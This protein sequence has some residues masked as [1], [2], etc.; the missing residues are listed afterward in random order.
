MKMY[1]DTN[2]NTCIDFNSFE[3]LIDALKPNS[4]LGNYP[5]QMIFRGQA[6]DWPLIPSLY[7]NGLDNYFTYTYRN[8]RDDKNKFFFHVEYSILRNYYIKANY[9]GLDIPKVDLFDNDYMN[10]DVFSSLGY[11]D[12]IDKMYGLNIN[13]KSDSYFD[14]YKISGVPEIAALAQHYGLPTRLI[15]WTQDIYIALYFAAMG[16]IKELYT[17]EN[18]TLD[19][20]IVI[21]TLTPWLLS[22]SPYSPIILEGALPPIKVIV[23]NYK[24]NPNIC[25]Q[26]GVLTYW[27]E[28]YDTG[29]TEFKCSQDSLDKRINE[30]NLGLRYKMKIKK[31]SYISKIFLPS[32]ECVKIVEYIN[33]L[34]YNA[35]TI[36]PW[37]DGISKYYEDMYIKS[38]VKE[39]YIELWTPSKTKKWDEFED[40][41]RMLDIYKECSDHQKGELIGYA[42][43]MNEQETCEGSDI[44][45]YGKAASLS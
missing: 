16:A 1:E 2:Q 20:K 42:M 9:L 32:S 36:F 23:P 27:K 11:K 39:K 44:E 33:R 18:Y 41:H 21:W 6:D 26:K 31:D 8:I 3:E 5:G 19:K 13:A 10:V 14:L 35:S 30:Y 43:H 7:R 22:T 12:N 37:H 38:Q 4:L 34:G 25:A 45:P 28:H 15:D 29:E 40:E 17:N 24:Q